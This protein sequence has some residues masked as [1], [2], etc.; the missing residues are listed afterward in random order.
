MT[1]TLYKLAVLWWHKMEKGEA[2][3]LMRDLY[4]NMITQ[5]KFELY[6]YEAYFRYACRMDYIVKFALAI[7][8][9]NCIAGWAI[10]EQQKEVWAIILAVSQV[11]QLINSLLPYQKRIEIIGPLH[12]ELEICYAGFENSF[13]KT[14]IS[15]L[16][17]VEANDIRTKYQMQWDEAENSALM[18]DAIPKIPWL[19]KSSDRAKVQYFR[20]LLGNEGVSVKTEKAHSMITFSNKL[21]DVPAIAQTRSFR[22]P[23]QVTTLKINMDEISLN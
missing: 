1:L 15:K 8:T 20:T 10:W 5:F 9:A 17:D 4:L 16:D 7:L 23:S 22:M 3:M 21:R 11:A 14:L 18:R 12:K 2:V 6:Y 19:V 13:I